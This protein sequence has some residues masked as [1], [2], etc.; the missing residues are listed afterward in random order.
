MPR[1]TQSPNVSGHCKSDIRHESYL[2]KMATKKTLRT[3]ENGHEDDKSSD[4]PTWPICE[5]ERKPND[6]FLSL[7][8]APARRALE[9]NDIFT[10]NAPAK[11]SEKEILK[12]H[13]IGKAS[14]PTLKKALAEK[15][16]SFKSN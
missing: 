2:P 15:D 1:R 10:L 6:G 13:G 8:S 3:W 11:Y 12:F 4:C 5:K 16:L 7:L 9:N 14:L